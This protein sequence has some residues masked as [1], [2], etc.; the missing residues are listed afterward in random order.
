[1]YMYIYI[2]YIYVCVYIDIYVCVEIMNI[3]TDNIIAKRNQADI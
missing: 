1:M 2:V 3:E